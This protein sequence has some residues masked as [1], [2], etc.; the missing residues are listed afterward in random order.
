MGLFAPST[1]DNPRPG[2][3]T[4]RSSR[5]ILK[6]TYRPRNLCDVCT[7][8]SRPVWYS[9]SEARTIGNESLEPFKAHQGAGLA[10]STGYHSTILE[11]APISDD[12]IPLHQRHPPSPQIQSLWRTFLNNVH[13]LTKM[14]FAWAKESVLQ[15]ASAGTEGLDTGEHSFC[16]SVYALSTLSLSDAECQAMLGGPRETTLRTFQLAAEAALRSAHYVSTRSLLVV[17]ALAMYMV[18]NSPCCCL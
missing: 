18:G 10:A 1:I 6:R 13:P 7:N 2:L 17:Q 12:N 8:G 15:K 5:P 9:W 14:F 3:L 16:F 4:T 11:S